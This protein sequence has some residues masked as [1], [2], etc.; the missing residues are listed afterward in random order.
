MSQS[1]IHVGVEF[2]DS[3][4]DKLIDVFEQIEDLVNNAAPDDAI[5]HKID[6]L[7]AETK[8]HFG[9]EEAFMQ[10]Y[11]FPQTALHM[12]M[13]QQLLDLVYAMTG[14]AEGVYTV[15]TKSLVEFL[16]S[17]LVEHIKAADADFGEFILKVRKS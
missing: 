13:H 10:E 9:R 16:R 3:D 11:S 15:P 8:I 5:Q 1:Q 12:R 7:I 6:T 4:H 17:W 2:I 14:R